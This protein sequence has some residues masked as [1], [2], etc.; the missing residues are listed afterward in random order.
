MSNPKFIPSA[1]LMGFVLCCAGTTAANAQGDVLGPPPNI[2]VIQREF[3]KPGRAGA[4]HEKSESAFIRAMRDH[5]ATVRYVGMTSQSGVSR[6]LFLNGYPTLA[7]WEKENTGVAG[8]PALAE[9]VERASV[10]DG[11]L[12]SSYE[13]SVWR[14][15]PDLS[16]KPG[17]AKGDRYMEIL[18]F[19]VRPG[20]AQEW[21]QIA[22]MVKDGYEKGDPT[23]HWDIFQSIFGTPGSSYLVIIPMKSLAE[24]DQDHANSK[25]FEDAMGKD[26]LMKL[27][28]MTAEAVSASSTNLFQFNPKMSFPPDAWV[29]AD[30]GFWNA[31]TTEGEQKSADSSTH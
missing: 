31:G 10:A 27:D 13:Q 29:K 28:Q 22:A 18:Q 23:G 5:H 12:L 4:A 8:D 3:V 15:R 7:A 30:P 6:A 26:G 9:D 11:D 21:E 1:L 14:Y 19:N 16:R 24:V 17:V 2:L 25:K 20:H